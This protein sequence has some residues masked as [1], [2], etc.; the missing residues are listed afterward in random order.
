M[1]NNPLMSRRTPDE[2]GVEYQKVRHKCEAFTAELERLIKHLLDEAA[3]DVQIEA[4]TKGINSFVE[5]IKRKNEKYKSPVEEVTDLCGIRIICYYLG[6]V[7]KV[8]ELVEREFEVDWPNSVRQGLDFD[9]DRFGYRSDHYVIGL[10]EPRGALVE[11]AGYTDLDAEIQVR[12][13]MQHAWA[14]VDHKIRYKRRDDL[15]SGLQRRLS[16][17]SAMLETADEQFSAI[18]EESRDLAAE[19]EESF[20]GGDFDI[21]LDVLSLQRFI[22]ATELDSKWATRALEIGFQNEPD[23]EAFFENPD[24]W[25][26][27][28]DF[29]RLIDSLRT[30]HLDSM[31]GVNDFFES[32]E[33]WG[34]SAL[35]RIL[36]ASKEHGLAPFAVPHDIMTFLALYQAGTLSAVEKHQYREPIVEGLK[37][38]IREKK[39]GKGSE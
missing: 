9:P 29:S 13:V 36:R 39:A 19:Y 28:A 35:E 2:W 18:Q 6:D 23:V 25:V 27:E 33:D 12:T 31:E 3:L 5:K 1:L 38:A 20:A 7:D 34:P 14:S 8:G 11:W 22:R 26:K 24:I 4:R 16:R 21:E 30:L 15:P 37:T 32:A 10:S 17:L